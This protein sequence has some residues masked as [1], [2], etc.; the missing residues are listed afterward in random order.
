M[1]REVIHP[2][3]PRSIEDPRVRLQATVGWTRDLEA[4]IGLQVE[5][6]DH[7]LVD[8][9]FGDTAILQGIGAMMLTDEDGAEP[10]LA[11]D[12]GRQAAEAEGHRVLHVLREVRNYVERDGIW[13]SLDRR[14]INTMIRHLRR[15]RDEAYGRDE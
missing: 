5:D 15:G 10:D 14:Q 3:T 13:M 2:S 7:R 9:L 11:T 6:P 1:P 4:Q 8:L 12:S